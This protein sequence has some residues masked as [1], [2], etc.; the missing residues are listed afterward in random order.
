MVIAGGGGG[1]MLFKISSKLLL[2][3][4]SLGVCGIRG[5]AP[6]TAGRRLGLRVAAGAVRGLRRPF[7]SAPGG[8]G[9]G[10][11]AGHGRWGGVRAGVRRRPGRGAARYPRSPPRSEEPSVRP[12]P[13]GPRGRRHGTPGHRGVV[14]VLRHV[15]S[16]G[17][18]PGRARA[19]SNDGATA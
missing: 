18:R 15:L 2:S 7:L 9:L 11:L 3:I 17:G 12:T 6:R 19:S 1:G 5:R 13:A 8:G 14:R 16:K 10:A 4:S